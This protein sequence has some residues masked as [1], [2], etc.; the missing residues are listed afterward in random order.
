MKKIILLLLCVVVLSLA[1]CG[2]KEEKS[3]VSNPANTSMETTI[4][5]ELMKEYVT[6]F[7]IDGYSK[8]YRIN[9]FKFE[10]W[11]KTI[12]SSEIEAII[13]A[14][15]NSNV[16]QRDPETVPYI[17]EAKKNAQEET[18]PQRKKILQNEYETLANEFG[19]P[20]ESN[21]Q[22]KLTA[23]LVDGGV[24]DKKSIKLFVAQ[25]MGKSIKYIP[26]E[27]ILPKI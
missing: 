8:Y 12:K 11:E 21:F 20:S 24:I 26:A 5:D 1:G 13:L 16:P 4:N 19:K 7:L 18:D 3:M 27:G 23:N 17:I 2:N 14:T 25:D 9:G 22:F 15:M 6:N 10:F